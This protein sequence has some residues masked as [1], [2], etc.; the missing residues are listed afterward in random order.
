V[1]GGFHLITGTDR[2]VAKRVFSD[3][4][5]VTVVQGTELSTTAIGVSVGVNHAFSSRLSVAAMVRKDFDATVNIDSAQYGGSTGVGG[6]YGLPWTLAAGMTAQV[7][8]GLAVALAAQY[9]AW[10][11]TDSFLVAFEAPGSGDTFE[12]TAG[13]ELATS[14][15]RLAQFPIRFGARYGT[16]PFKVDETTQPYEFAVS[17][18]GGGRFA[19][20]RAGIDMSLERVWRRGG[21]GR[22]ETA[23][24][25]Y[26]GINIRP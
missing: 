16:L 22:S 18:G 7:R 5:F 6:T 14:S 2:L 21:E 20:D 3:S 12:V 26:T 17:L 4:N 1:G 10:S 25:L 23:W 19:R 15:R 24:L 13:A 8:S 11:A 9:R